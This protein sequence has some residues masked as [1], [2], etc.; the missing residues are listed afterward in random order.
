MDKNK[1]GGELIFGAL[2]LVFGTLL[3]LDN[4]DIIDTGPL[5]RYWPFGIV[6]LGLK[7]ILNSESRK[8]LGS[9]IW[10]VFLGLWLFVSIYRIFGLAL[11]DTWPMLLVAWGVSEIWKA[12]PQHST[13]ELAKEDTHAH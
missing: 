1:H 8:E 13:V 3:L 7:R 2:L 11:W 5:W 9:G 10:L 6:A 4:V 12:L